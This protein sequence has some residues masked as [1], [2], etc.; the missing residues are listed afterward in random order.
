MIRRNAIKSLAAAAAIMALGSMPALAEG[1]P[2]KPITIIVPYGAGGSSDSYTRAF[3]DYVEKKFGT[4]LIIDNRDG[5]GGTIGTEYLM[6]QPADGY[7]VMYMSSAVLL[8]FLFLGKEVQAGKDLE[9][10]GGLNLTLNMWMVNPDVIDVNNMAEMVQYFKD[11]PGTPYGTSGVGST[12]HLTFEAFVKSQGLDVEH[13]PYRGSATAMTALVSGEIGVI[14]GS[15]PATG[16]PQVNAGAVRVIATTGEERAAFLPDMPTV[17]E[18]GFP[19]LSYAAIGG[20]VAPQG[21]PEDVKGVLVG[22]VQTAMADPEF[23]QRLA[24]LGTAPSYLSP[25]D[26]TAVL[27]METARAAEMIK[28]TGI[29]PN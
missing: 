21:L 9:A 23:T 16:M 17:S 20:F 7:T 2:S 27:N 28:T 8:S 4:Q 26:L 6:R 22:W 15:D 3:A 13:I 29:T 11:H 19:E 5:A 1:F 25:D 14:A 24:A 18:Q 10:L 12:P